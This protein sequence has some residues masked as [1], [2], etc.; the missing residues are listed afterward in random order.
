[1]AIVLDDTSSSFNNYTDTLSWSHTCAGSDRILIVAPVLLGD[2]PPTHDIVSITYNGVALTKVDDQDSTGVHVEMWYLVAPA[3]G[4]HNIVITHDGTFTTSWCLGIAKSF[5]G[6]DQTSPIV[7]SGKASDT[8]NAVTVSLTST[9]ATDMLLSLAGK[10]SVGDNVVDGASQTETL[11]DTVDAGWGLEAGFGYKQS[12]GGGS[13]ALNW[14][15]T[16]SNDGA[17]IAVALKAAVSSTTPN[18]AFAR[19]RLLV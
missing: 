11:H 6:V 17:E 16:D 15:W 10:Y 13:Q 7:T 12:S 19:R 1:M 4:A 3:T 5:T 9:D 8:G 14:T 18:P 2:A